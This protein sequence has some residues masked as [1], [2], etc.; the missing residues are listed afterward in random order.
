MITAQ[1]IIESK[2]FCDAFDQ[3]NSEQYANFRDCD[4]GDTKQL[5]GLALKCWALSEVRA[6]LE[7][8]M[9]RSVETRINRKV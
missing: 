5:Q 7:A 1:D 8:V 4:P 3:L 9:A 6:E 2:V